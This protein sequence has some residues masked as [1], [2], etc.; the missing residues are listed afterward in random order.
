MRFLIIVVIFGLLLLALNS[1]FIVRETEQVI[2]TQF[3]Q[4]QGDPI[5]EP[6]LHWKVPFV[7][8]VV[9]FDKR[10]LEWQGD[11]EELPTKDKVF[12][13]VDNYARWRIA[14]PKK[15]FERLGDER[16]AQ[17]RLDDIIDGETRNALARHNLIEVIRSTNRVPIV[18]ESVQQI[19]ENLVRTDDPENPRHAG[20]DDRWLEIEAGRDRIRQQILDAAKRRME[21]DLG[22]EILDVQF[23]RINYGESVERDVFNRMVSERKRIAD[24]YRSQGRGEQARILGDM[25]R[26]LKKIQSEA[27][28]EAEEIRG[29]ADAKATEVY[30][31]AYNQSADSRSFYEFL[32][33]METFESTVDP[34]TVLMLSTEGDFYRYLK[35]SR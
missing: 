25:E 30:A 11:A 15:F 7:Q 10:F 24:R 22:I 29:R 4:V 35:G 5:D 32:K 27:Y 16:G 28:R 17:S 31:S 26:D 6:G 9:A 33:T 20:G 14:D 8:K 19:A 18:D 1:A 13:F 21:A 12:I 34:E 23:R 3:G 2:I